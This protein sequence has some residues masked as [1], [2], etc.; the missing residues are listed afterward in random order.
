M[1]RVEQCIKTSAVGFWKHVKELQDMDADE[2]KLAAAKGLAQN[3]ISRAGMLNS[4][5][6]TRK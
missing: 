6:T 1:Y 3:A 5:C 4:G 2:V